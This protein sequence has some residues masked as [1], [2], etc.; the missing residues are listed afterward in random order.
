MGLLLSVQKLAKSYGSLPLFEDI[1]FFLEERDVMGLVGPNG[2]GKSTLL[3][4]IAGIESPDQGDIAKRQG[5]KV[6]YAGQ[7]PLFA[8]ATLLD[9]LLSV[10]PFFD[11]EEKERMARMW[12]EKGGFCDPLVSP[13]SLSGGWKKRLDIVKGL[14]QNPDVF[15]LDEPTNHL[16]FDGILWLE[17]V[18]KKEPRAFLLISHDRCFLENVCQKMLEL[19][20]CFPKGTFTCEGGWFAFVEKREEFLLW[21]AKKEKSLALLVKEEMEWM[22]RSPKARTTKAK[23]RIAKAGALQEE[24]Q[25]VGERNRCPAADIQFWGSQRQTRHLL[26]AKNL[27]KT[28]GGT[29]LFSGVDVKLSPGTRLGIVGKNGTGKSSLLR[30]LAGQLSPDQGTVKYAQDLQMVYF[31]QHREQLPLD[32][33]LQEALSPS[34]DFVRFQGQEIHV[35][36]WAKRFLFAPDRLR[37]PLRVLSGGER[38]RILIA[39]LMLQPADVLFLDEPTNDLDT[40][41]LEIMENNLVDFPGAIVL[42]THDRLLLDRLCTQVLGLGVG[43]DTSLLADYAQW[44][45]IA[46]AP[47]SLVKE[48]KEGSGI[49]RKRASLSYLEKKELS[50]MEGRILAQEDKVALLAKEAPSSL[51]GSLY[52]VLAQEQERLDQLYARWQFLENKSLGL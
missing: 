52:K 15:L 31:D 48:G 41:T 20:S 18:I 28:L 14:I 44:E 29:C 11:Q 7:F 27:Q 33:S 30:I 8:C 34:G 51:Q 47:V 16:D 37:L 36:G 46:F 24:W 3:K 23:S 26:V 35:H 2:A 32:V 25:E 4:I 50:E 19:N 40:T 17:K 49:S 1:S 13:E 12:L 22:S 45:R 39:R 5:L 10:C 6:A 43:Q 9:E 38:A 42:I 21:Q